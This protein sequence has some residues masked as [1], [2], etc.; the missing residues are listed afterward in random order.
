VL[1]E[2][3]KIELIWV[4]IPN[5]CSTANFHQVI[6]FHL[7]SLVSL[8]VTRKRRRKKFNALAKMC[9]QKTEKLNWFE[10]IFLIHAQLPTF[11]K[12]FVSI[13]TPWSLWMLQ[14]RGEGKSS[15]R[16]PRYACKS[17]YFVI[18]L[19]LYS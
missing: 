10:F 4:Y 18:Y 17:L 16:S 14:G 6:C 19:S 5:S 8:D 7:D 13:W 9:S 3:W 12:L 15:A 11:T 2:N 1:A